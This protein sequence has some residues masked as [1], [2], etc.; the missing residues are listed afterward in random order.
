MKKIRWM[1]LLLAVLV[2]IGLLAPDTRAAGADS[3]VTAGCNTVDAA[4]P[5]SHEGQLLETAK[6]VLLYD[7]NS[8]TMIYAYNPDLQVYPA[9]LVRIMAVMVALEH[10]SL[11]DEVVVNQSAL[12]NMDADAIVFGLRAG[13]RLS[14]ESLLYLMIVSAANDPGPV[15]AEHVAGSQVEFAKLMNEKAAELGCTGT[16]FTNAHGL[17]DPNN[18]TTA[19]DLLRITK[20]ALENPVIRKMFE[21]EY[22]IVPAIA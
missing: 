15:V 14:L 5:L 21:S 13:E 6:S 20:A 3:S 2:L 4:V 19:R 8:D 10:A 12:M 9:S 1:P 16:N 22:Y 17:H 7:L 18:Y 11:T